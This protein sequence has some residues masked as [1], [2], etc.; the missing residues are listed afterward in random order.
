MFAVGGGGRFVRCGVGF[1]E[2]SFAALF[3]FADEAGESF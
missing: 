3:R 1:F 2:L